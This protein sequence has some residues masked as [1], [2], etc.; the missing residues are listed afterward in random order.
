MS[1]S[2]KTARAAGTRWESRIVTAL[3]DAG[4]IHAERRRLSGARDR[5]DI[6][7]VPGLVIEAKDTNRMA[8]A[9]AVDEA[10]AE[11]ANDNGSIGAA[12]IKRRGK[13]GAE[14]GYVV[15]QG[16]HFLRL[17]GEARYK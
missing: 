15:M 10:V 5:G 3:Q 6:T 1:R 13:S 9:E 2:R 11:A 17:L 12:W 7:G 14:E 4:F 8:L 16:D